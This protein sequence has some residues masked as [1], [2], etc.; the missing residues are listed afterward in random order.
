MSLSWVK[1]SSPVTQRGNEVE[2]A[3]HT[4][5][6]NVSAVESTLIMQVALKL[7]IDVGDNGV[8]TVQEKTEHIMKHLRDLETTET[9]KEF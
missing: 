6:H 1:K 8:K 7:V 3:V 5:V 4:V 9:F 2:A